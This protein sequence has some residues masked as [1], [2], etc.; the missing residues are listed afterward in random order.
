M[1][2]CSTTVL[3]A[4]PINSVC[5]V[6]CVEERL[7]V[8]PVGFAVDFSKFNGIIRKKKIA[9]HHLPKLGHL[10]HLLLFIASADFS[11]FF[12]LCCFFFILSFMFQMKAF[13]QV[14]KKIIIRATQSL[15]YDL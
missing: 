13:K 2:L 7:Y 15:P 11:F 9:M 1:R 6:Q 12:P 5:F 10:K 4:W 14:K 8:S 3:T